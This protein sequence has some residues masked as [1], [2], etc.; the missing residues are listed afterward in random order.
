MS[1]VDIKYIDTSKVRRTI[2]NLNFGEDLIYQA[3]SQ[4]NPGFIPYVPK[5][6]LDSVIKENLEMK[7]RIEELENK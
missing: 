5:R 6:V 4:S 3:H 1:K 7:K 2:S